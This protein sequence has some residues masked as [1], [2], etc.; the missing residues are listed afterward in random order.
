M[1]FDS[2]RSKVR[3]SALKAAEA[4]LSVTT[5]DQMAANDDYIHSEG[6][7][8]S[9][10]SNNNKRHGASEKRNEFTPTETIQ[11]SQTFLGRVVN[12]QPLLPMV[13]DLVKD[14]QSEKNNAKK[15]DD[16]SDEDD[17]GDDPILSMIHKKPFNLESRHNMQKL[18][19]EPNPVVGPPMETEGPRRKNPNRFMTDLDERLS[20]EEEDRPTSRVQQHQPLSGGST[21]QTRWNLFQSVTSSP[22]GQYFSQQMGQIDR[23][24][25]DQKQ[26]NG[27][28]VPRRNDGV[29]KDYENDDDNDES[30]IQLI[31][32]SSVLGAEETAELE[33]MRIA[34]QHTTDPLTMVLHMLKQNPH[35][36]F[37]IVTLVLGFAAYFYSRNRGSEDDVN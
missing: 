22:V 9:R 4:A 8:I 25:K 31:V 28:L 10:K 15:F 37:I 17:D 19:H 7:N 30:K 29:T 3:A 21:E 11:T 16:V 26:L 18:I 35:N 14:K 20:R 36:A 2:F 5:L 24:E 13:V 33:R 32:S 6:L 23:S 12:A 34:T 1:N 27:P